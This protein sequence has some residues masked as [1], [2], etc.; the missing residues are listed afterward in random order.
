MA[1]LLRDIRHRASPKP[2]NGQ[3]I[4]QVHQRRDGHPRRAEAQSAANDRVEHPASHDHDDSR[5]HFDMNNLARCPRFAVLPAQ[6]A[7]MQR[8]PA[9]MNDD[10]RPDMGRMTP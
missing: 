8:V 10:F 3:Q 7:A 1:S 5:R 9:V 2:E 6:A 4:M